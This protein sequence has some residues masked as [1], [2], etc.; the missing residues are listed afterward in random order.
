MRPTL[1]PFLVLGLTAAALAL[2]AAPA[3][4]DGAADIGAS[5]S[6]TVTFSLKNPKTQHINDKFRWS[7]KDG[8]GNKLKDSEKN[9][10]D[11]SFSKTSATVTVVPGKLKGGYCDNDDVPNGGCHFF[12]ATCTDKGCTVDAS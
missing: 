12:T 11:F 9:K 8:G 4:A 7:I 6:G 1:R 2:G 5:G 10:G 3:F